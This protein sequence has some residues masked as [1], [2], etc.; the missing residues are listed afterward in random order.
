LLPH[1]LLEE[2][3]EKPQKPQSS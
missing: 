1:H 2:T 3:E